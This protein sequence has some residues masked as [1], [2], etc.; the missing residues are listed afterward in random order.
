MSEFREGRVRAPAHI[1]ATESTEHL[2]RAAREDQVRESEECR[3]ARRRDLLR[4]ACG[5]LPALGVQ[6]RS[7]DEHVQEDQHRQD[8]RPHRITDQLGEEVGRRKEARRVDH[9]QDVQIDKV[10]FRHA[11]FVRVRP[12]NFDRAAHLL[13]DDCARDREK[14]GASIRLRS[15]PRRRWRARAARRARGNQQTELK[16]GATH[17]A[18]S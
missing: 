6:P 2:E 11:F 8:D 12:V 14:Q 17:F 13:R 7:S 15:N 3:H 16:A 10:C 1:V 4:L 5:C 18:C 9:T